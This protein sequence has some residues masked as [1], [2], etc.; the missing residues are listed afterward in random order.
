MS[1]FRYLPIAL[2]WFVFLISIPVCYSQYVIDT[3]FTST[4]YMYRHILEDRKPIQ[5]PANFSNSEYIKGENFWKHFYTGENLWQFNPTEVEEFEVSSFLPPREMQI[6]TTNAVSTGGGRYP[7]FDKVGDIDRFFAFKLSELT[8]KGDYFFWSIIYFASSNGSYPL[9]GLNNRPN[10]KGMTIVDTLPPTYPLNK[11]RCDFYD[12]CY[13]QNYEVTFD[14]PRSGDRW[15]IFCAPQNGEVGVMSEC[16]TKASTAQL[17]TKRNQQPVVATGYS[18]LLDSVR[19]KSSNHLIFKSQKLL[20]QEK[21][22]KEQL[23]LDESLSVEII[24]HTDDIGNDEDNLVLSQL[25]ANEFASEL[26]SLGVSPNRIKV[27]GLGSS[28][29]IATNET[30]EGRKTNRR[31]EVRFVRE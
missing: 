9:V 2:V 26:I 21:F 17:K 13:Y 15:L 23:K 16:Y 19:F 29:P 25:R 31:V 27:V 10:L 8:K 7:S 4:P 3:C 11:D 30:E 14:F 22:I 24:G 28:K 20:K 5:Y 18:F 6:E 1:S 12:I